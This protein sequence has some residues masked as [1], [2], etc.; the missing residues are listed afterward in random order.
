MPMVFPEND[1]QRGCA[2]CGELTD[3]D[4]T[5]AFQP[6]VDT[7]KRAI[8]GYEALL[9]DRV[10]RTAETVLGKV[11]ND[12]RYAFDQMCRT[13]AIYMASQLGL[14]KVLS[15]NFLPNAVYEPRHCIQSTLRTAKA[16]GFP[17]E[18]IMFEVTESEKVMNIAHLR[19]I[20][21]SY[22]ALGSITALDDFGA[23]YAGLNVLANF[24]PMIIKLDIELVKDIHKLEAKKIIAQAMR[25]LTQKLGVQLLAEG[26]ECIEEVRFFE[27]LGVHLMQGFFFAKPGYEHLPEVNFA[28]LN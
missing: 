11:T 20:F 8:F 16:C 12:N 10:T 26:V 25:E 18:N 4:F 15:I 17:V 9:R 7:Q 27:G 23:G 1:R 2:K 28:M 22:R 14:N 21:E 6:M 13:K 5:Y 24:Q 19:H 3:F